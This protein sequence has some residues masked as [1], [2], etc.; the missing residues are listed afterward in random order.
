[1]TPSASIYRFAVNVLVP[2]CSLCWNTSLVFLHLRQQSKTNCFHL[3]SSK[4][5][6][7]RSV[8]F[9]F[10]AQFKLQSMKHQHLLNFSFCLGKYDGYHS[11]GAKILAL[12]PCGS[13]ANILHLS[14]DILYIIKATKFVT[15]RSLGCRVAHTR[16]QHTRTHI[17]THTHKH[18]THTPHLTALNSVFL[19]FTIFAPH[20]AHLVHRNKHF[21]SLIALLAGI[22]SHVECTDL[23]RYRNVTS[24]IHE[25]NDCEYH[26]HGCSKWSKEPQWIP[27]PNGVKSLTLG[28]WVLSYQA[29]VSSAK[30]LRITYWKPKMIICVFAGGMCL[31]ALHHY[32]LDSRVLTQ[33]C[34]FAVCSRERHPELGTLSS[35]AWRKKRAMLRKRWHF[36]FLFFAGR[37]MHWTWFPSLHCQEQRLKTIAVLF[38]KKAEKKSRGHSKV[39]I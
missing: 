7:K 1:M 37:R 33:T 5:L 22:A 28:S 38:S 27:V 17:H 30:R 11:Q 6:T 26:L 24:P 23:N 20:F 34:S 13:R 36:L 4:E 19:Y 29:L 9:F 12:E 32:F 21:C 15:W 31:S 14:N 3:H 8:D 25:N 18:T 39:H 16:A 35:N 10:F 2:S